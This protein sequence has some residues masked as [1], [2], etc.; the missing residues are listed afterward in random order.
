VLLLIST[1]FFLF[2]GDLFYLILGAVFLAVSQSFLSGTGSA[3]MHETL[4]GLN[5]EGE[6]TA[7]MGKVSSVG[8]AV[9][10]ILAS[11]TPFLVAVSYK[12]PFVLALVFD[13]VGL[14]IALL[15]VRPHVAQEEI[16]E[17]GATNFKGVL[18]EGY[19]LGYLKHAIFIGI[20]SGFTFSVSYFRDVYQAFLEF[21]VIYF[22]ILFGIGRLLASLMLAYSGKI[23]GLFTLLSLYR[24]K[25]FLYA[26]ILLIL[27]ISSNVWVVISVFIIL[28]AFKWGLSQ[29]TRGFMLEIISKSKFKATLLSVS[30]QVTLLFSS[31]L[32]FGLGIIIEQFSFK[33]G[34]LWLGITFLV[35]T[36]PFY[37]YIHRHEI[38]R[39]A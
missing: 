5:R 18:N 20:I 34:F 36:I 10:V 14:V 26:S 16:E 33:F 17:I 24:F 11:L 15:L 21:P 37:L 27:A 38:N 35:I 2:A 23:K 25:L 29:V 8:F 9:P 39:S 3:F 4:R 6:Y 28:N 31:I 1:S 22:G 13:A 7:V 32:S 30:S 12:A 19:N